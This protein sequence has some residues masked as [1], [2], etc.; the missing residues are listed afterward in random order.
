M[1]GYNYVV[2]ANRKENVTHG[3]VAYLRAINR[4]RRDTNQKLMCMKTFFIRVLVRGMLYSSV[5]H[6]FFYFRYM[7]Y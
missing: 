2:V 7:T 3:N 4:N 1:Q 6:A 5:K